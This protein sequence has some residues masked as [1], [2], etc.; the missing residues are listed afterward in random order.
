MMTFILNKKIV[1]VFWLTVI[2]RL[3]VFAADLEIKASVDQTRIGLNQ[4][5]TLNVELSGKDAQGAQNP[6]IPD[7]NAFASFLGSGSSQNIQIV[8]GK[9]SV[10]KVINYYFQAT[11]AG[12]FQIPPVQVVHKGATLISDPIDIEIVGSSSSNT[13]QSPSRST[14]R[15]DQIAQGAEDELFLR[16]LVSKTKVYPNEPV[17]V[18]FKLYTRINVSSF[19]FTKMPN[20][21]GFW[22]EDYEL[23]QRP[24]TGTEVY[25]GKQYTV[26]TLKKMIL[27]PTSA[28]QKTIDPM[29]VECQV[30]VQRRRGN[31]SVFDDF[32]DDSF[33]FGQTE[34][35]QVS[36]KPV[37]INVL[38]LPEEGKPVNYSGMVGQFHIKGSVDK[39]QV[40]T[41]EAVTYKV[42][43]SGQGNLHSLTEPEVQF[44][45]DFEVYPPKINETI[46]R[47]DA[48]LSGSKT[49]EY[50][51]V[52]RNAGA[53]KIK[54]VL[55]NY[56]DARTQ[57]YKTIQTDPV[58][59]QVAQGSQQYA[60]IPT[61]LSKEEVQLV[62]QD[63]RF[64]KMDALNLRKQGSH[65]NA[66]WIFWIIYLAPLGLVWLAFI[67]RKHLNL[68]VE[69]V[70]YARDRRAQKEA[71]KRLSQAKGCQV[72][73]T[74][75]E[76][77]AE[78]GKA[79]TGFLGDKL[80]IAE[81]GMMT[82][83]VRKA[84]SKKGIS[85]EVVEPYFACL[86]TCDM[87]RFSPSDATDEEMTAFYK[88][89]ETAILDMGRALAG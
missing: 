40:S 66:P 13:T 32:F 31:R 72:V 47:N 23:P 78:I 35:R 52:P 41:N 21:A 57:T 59:I 38:P 3:P 17:I 49:F 80:N 27:F 48:G 12:K 67:Y 42:V 16:V 1:S 56:F 68:L 6:Q 29:A 26:A 46:D 73:E 22:T 64:I 58:T 7:V 74:Q 87:K 4:Q 81:A 89:A 8:N 77:Y 43:I 2:L 34:A 45:Q 60:S 37:K 19:G 14:A 39:T 30:R 18:T 9:M 33:F 25:K 28:G 53:Q 70:A 75:K 79:L 88:Q 65:F 5:F 61:G 69:D 83:E 24:P 11:Q 10:T 84:L 71:R 15:G 51:L 55:F 76:F 63:V 86:A 36:S 82:D 20:T 85:S 44:S 62:G 54:P 50:V